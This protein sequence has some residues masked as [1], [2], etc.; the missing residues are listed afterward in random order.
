ME[1]QRGENRKYIGA[2]VADIDTCEVVDK[3]DRNIY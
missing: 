3:D 2:T 1:E